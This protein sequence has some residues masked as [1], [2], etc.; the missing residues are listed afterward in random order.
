MKTHIVLLLTMKLTRHHNPRRRLALG[1]LLFLQSVTGVAFCSAGESGF[2]SDP[3]RI[4]P[5]G[6]NA[7]GMRALEES[8]KQAQAPE[9]SAPKLRVA[10][11]SVPQASAPKASAPVLSALIETGARSKVPLCNAWTFQLGEVEGAELAGFD[12]SAWR[13]LDVPHDWSIE[14]PFDENLHG[15]SSVGYLPGGIGWYRKAFSLPEQSRGKKVL[16]DF[17][18]VYMDSTV[19]VN[20]HRLGGQPYGYTSFQFDLSPYLNFGGEPNVIAVRVN[21][22]HRSAR[23]YPGAGIYRRVW[24]TTVNPVHIGQ[25]GTYVTTPEI[26]E[27]EA[28]VRVRTELENESTQDE[29]VQLALSILDADGQV[30]AEISSTQTVPAG[31]GY[32]F[33]QQMVVED[34]R[35]WS[36]DAPQLYDVVSEV[37]VNGRIVDNTVT[38]TGIRSIEFTKDRGF[39][40]N[41]EHVDI[42]GMCLHHDFGVIG[43]A[44]YPRAMEWQLEILRK[45]GC[46][47][48]RTSTTPFDPEFYAICDRMG[49]LV[50]DDILDEW[51]LDK[52][53]NGY[54]QFFDEWSEHDVSSMVR[55]DRNHPSVILWS[56]GNEI[57]EQ[58]D[59]DGGEV[60]KRLVEI[61]KKLDTTRPVTAC[62]NSPIQAIANGVE[63][64]L[65][66]LGLNYQMPYYEQLKGDKPMISTE[67]ATSFSTRG[68]Y[69][70]TY[71]PTMELEILDTNNNSECSSYG[72]FWGGLRSEETLMTI[73]KSP[74]MAGHFAWVGID[75]IGECFPFNWPSHNAHFGLVDMVGFPKDTYYLYQSEWLEKPVVHIVPQNWNWSRYPIRK[76]PVWVYSNCEEVEL[77]LNG[78]SL[79]TK[80]IDRDETLHFEWLVPW[81][82]GTLKAVGRNAAKEV[83]ADSVQTAGEPVEVVL[84]TDRTEIAA[85]GWDL[86][87]VEA[88]LVDANGTLCPDSDMQL[89]F[90]IEGEGTILGIG[91]GNATSMESFKG[92]SYHTYRGLCR[93]V[94][95]ST[96][97]AGAIR[98]TGTADGLNSVTL[99]LVSKPGPAAPYG[100]PPAEGSYS[101]SR[102][103]G[104]EYVVKQMKGLKAS[105]SSSHAEHPPELAIDGDV[106]TRWCP[107]D[108]NTGHS[109]QLNLGQLR[110]LSGAKIVWQTGGRYQY[111]VEG[112]VDGKSWVMLSDQSNRKELQQAHELA[113]EHQGLRH[114]RITTTGLPDGLWGTFMEVEM[115]ESNN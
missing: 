47:A 93:V 44:F 78:K 77:F 90:N 31:G 112:S 76:V 102:I 26:S 57:N 48:I 49:F 10:Q 22:L 82:P 32:E 35:L 9:T 81:R 75:Y 98:L 80:T 14:Q 34:P 105:A 72:T 56:V 36:V 114:V 45:M 17:D 66:V 46:N 113:F 4:P 2:M 27:S 91:S 70:Y 16:I 97:Q 79:G 38:T 50:M 85:D 11:A 95:K 62:L 20:G 86:S 37:S 12:D 68:S 108:G 89:T 6:S 104:P 111:V 40:L 110:D 55:R 13:S 21:A 61:V 52:L 51:K 103:A 100:T 71:G 99:D 33:D 73:R 5:P 83:C 53:S 101:R 25:W 65:D 106:M 94:I 84:V 69:P 96:Q 39:F 63:Q 92:N 30:V 23:W 60:A 43:T 87:F 18:G 54:G 15:G 59:K 67:S 41:G 107:K 58:Y 1:A 88:R 74:W 3:M 8:A 42:K 19:W 24:L 109:W 7:S 29:I 28:V 64:P 115:Y